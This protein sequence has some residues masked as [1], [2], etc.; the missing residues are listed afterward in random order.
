MA[1]GGKVG[2]EGGAWLTNAVQRMV[3]TPASLG[4]PPVVGRAQGEHGTSPVERGRQ[5]V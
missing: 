1:S 5:E 3:Q 4:L 2:L